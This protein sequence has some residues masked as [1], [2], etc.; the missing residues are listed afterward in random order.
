MTLNMDV[1]DARISHRPITVISKEYNSN[2][3]RMKWKCD[4][5]S[6]EWD[7]TFHHIH[8]SNSG[9]PNCASFKSERLCRKYFQTFLGYNFPKRRLECMEKLELDGYC[10]ELKLAFEYQGLQHF[11]NIPY[12]HKNEDSLK[13]QQERDKEEKLVQG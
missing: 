7:A 2:N 5:C 3:H 8:D 6:N 10:E 4:I 9:C 11:K 1:V 13:K 12:F